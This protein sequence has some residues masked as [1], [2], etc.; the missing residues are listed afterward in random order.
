MKITKSQLKG[1]IREA[2]EMQDEVDAVSELK[3]WFIE[4]SKQLSSMKI[5]NSQVP[6]LKNAI[7][8]LLASAAAGT[9][10]RRE[11]FLDAQLDKIK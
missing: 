4:T 7:E 8:K 9:L 2:A 3:V 10:K 6:A 5:S 1:I 11:S